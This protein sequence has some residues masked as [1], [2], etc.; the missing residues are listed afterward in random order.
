MAMMI[1]SCTAVWHLAI[2]NE[3]G[4]VFGRWA[5]LFGELMVEREREKISIRRPFQ[6][7]RLM[8]TEHRSLLMSR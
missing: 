1:S 2:S 5:K 3:H 8:R 7:T 4:G 6:P